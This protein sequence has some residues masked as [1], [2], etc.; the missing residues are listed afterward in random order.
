VTKKS[1]GADE[2]RN[3]LTPEHWIAA[4]TNLLVDGGVDLVRVDVIAKQ[5]GVTRG[6]FYWHFKDRDDLLQRVLQAWRDAATEQVTQR[7]AD[8][9]ADPA[10]LV[11][12][13]INLPFRGRAALRAAR[14]ELAI[15][16]W[17][18]RDPMARQAVDEADATRV[19]YIAQCFS[20]LGFSI[21]EARLRAGVLYA[22]ELGES[23]MAHQGSPQQKSER[24][25]VLEK[26]LLSGARVA[27]RQER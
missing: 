24:S 10:E 27:E 13:L 26:M 4:A 18:R 17:A 16:D 23:L 21:P 20:A 25:A 11:H 9:T 12:E 3:S 19:S 8:I 5:I 15:R 14:I 2:A 22:Y 6:S 1:T 7:F